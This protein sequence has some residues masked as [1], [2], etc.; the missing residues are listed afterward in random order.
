MTRA[1]RLA[2]SVLYVVAPVAA[3]RAAERIGRRNALLTAE[4]D[5]AAYLARRADVA[6]RHAAYKAALATIDNRQP[7]AVIRAEMARHSTAIYGA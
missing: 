1:Q 5:R 7:I 2:L 4:A 6:K 3:I